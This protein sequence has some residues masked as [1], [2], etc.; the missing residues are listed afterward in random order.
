MVRNHTTLEH[1]MTC[2]IEARYTHEIAVACAWIR[3][4]DYERIV[5][6]LEQIV[7]TSS[8][9]TQLKNVART[10]VWSNIDNAYN[11]FGSHGKTMLQIEADYEFFKDLAARAAKV[12]HISEERVGMRFSRRVGWR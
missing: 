9:R 7:I 6:H 10:V 12:R 5:E 8:S 1:V 11:H 3:W 2:I 4:Q